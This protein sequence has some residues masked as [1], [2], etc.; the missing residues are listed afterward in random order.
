MKIVK[1][2]KKSL[3]F[4]PVTTDETMFSLNFLKHY[5]MKITQKSGG[6]PTG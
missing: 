5:T 1:T 3:T 2:L 4:L 6:W